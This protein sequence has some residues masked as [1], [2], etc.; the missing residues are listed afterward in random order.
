MAPQ[1]RRAGDRHRLE[2][3]E[4]AAR[5]VGEQPEGGVGDAGGDGDEQDAGQQVVDVAAAADVDRAA[6]DVDEQ[7]QHGDRRD[8]R[9]DD[10]VGAAQDVAQGPLEQDGGVVN[11]VGGHRWVLACP[12][13][14]RG[15]RSRGRCPR[16][17]AASRRTR[18]WR[19]GAAALSSARVPSAMIRPSCRIAIRSASCSASS[20][21][22]V[23][24]S[25]VVPWPAS[26][27][28]GPPDLDAATAGRARSSARRGRAR[29]G[30]RSGS[31][32]CR[33]GG[34]CR[35]SRSPTRCAGRVGRASNRAS[36]SS[37]IPPGS[38]EAPQLGDEHEVLPPGEDLVD[39]GELAGE[40]DRLADL[41]GLGGDVVPVDGGGAAVGPEQRGQDPH[42]GGLAGAVGAE[43]GE[44]GARGD[45]QVDAP[46]APRGRRRTW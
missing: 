28:D 8:G 17:S 23:V 44:D 6:E 45:A 18:P 2:P 30:R 24:S 33:G 7:Q 16:G 3:L 11:D 4:D 1:H 15:R 41:R 25:T 34:A 43:Q 13:A 40:A 46:R 38:G 9:G 26:S 29:A 14:C 36:R 10:R 42:R 35:R 32:R 39:G 37:A 19:A 31:S 21:Y 22:C 27:L 20:R 5:D 12:V